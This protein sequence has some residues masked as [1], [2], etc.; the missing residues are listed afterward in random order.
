MN[1]NVKSYLEQALRSIV[2]AL[3]NIPSEIIIVDNASTDGSQA[4]VRSR[5]PQIRLIANTENRGFARANNQALK[6]A[7]GRYVCLINPDTLVREDTFREC[8]DYME[9]HPKVGM[10]GCK[11]LNP[12]GSLQLACRRSYPTPWVGFT[13][14]VGLSSLFPKSRFFGRYNLTYLDP[15]ETAE[16]EAISGSFMFVRRKAVDEAGFLD[17]AFFLYGEDLD[18]CY[19]IRK[20]GWTIIYLPVTQIIHYKGRSAKEAPFDNLRIFYSAMRLFVRKHFQSGWA[21]LPQWFLMIGIWLRSGIGFISQLLQRLLIPAIDLFFLQIGLFIAILI[22]LKTPTYWPRYFWV[23]AIYSTIWLGCFWGMGL[24]HRSRF[25]VSNAIGAVFFGFVLNTSVTF[26]LPEYQFSR[27]VMLIAAFLDAFLLGGWRLVIRLATKKS[28]FVLFSKLGQSM[29]NRRVVVAGTGNAS[30]RILKQLRRHPGTGYE[31]V[32]IVSL[33]EE[34]DD[35]LKTKSIP[36]LGSLKD[37]ERVAVAHRIHEVIF[38]AELISYS[39]IL[40]LMSRSKDLHLDFKMVPRQMDVLIGQSNVD[41]LDELT[42]MDLDYPIFQGWNLLF[43]RLLDLICVVIFLPFSL[44]TSLYVLLVPGFQFKKE[45]I[46][47]GMGRHLWIIRVWKR[48]RRMHGWIQNL[49]LIFPLFLGRMSMVGTEIVPFQSEMQPMGFKPGLTGIVQIH[50]S[51]Q[52]TNEEKMRYRHYY[53]KNYSIFLDIE[54]LLKALFREQS[55]FL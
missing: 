51:R 20:A 13:K 10:T 46:S 34:T 44:F 28:R 39:Q 23:N 32:G 1:Y 2:K 12:D 36:L 25:S 29:V 55:L 4:M 52:L 35:K 40:T 37:I 5:F 8:L 17:E 18:W 7:T 16:V 42:L 45:M 41:A 50:R 48:D 14:A 30:Q 38:P 43:K 27:A 9:S 24:Y 19:R 11:I 22:W 49:F 26:F 6:E 33:A 54:I 31:V 21:F 15:E 53:M 3:K 47:D